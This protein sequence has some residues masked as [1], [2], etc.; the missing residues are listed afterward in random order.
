MRTAQTF[1]VRN[2]ISILITQFFVGI[3]FSYF[4]R[5]TCCCT[6]SQG[7]SA[8]IVASFFT[9]KNTCSGQP[10]CRF[11]VGAFL[12]WVTLMSASLPRTV[13]TMFSLPNRAW[14][15]FL[16]LSYFRHKFCIKFML[17]FTAE[18][19]CSRTFTKASPDIRSGPSASLYLEPL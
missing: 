2:V 17:K 11:L 4:S 19:H 10:S 18:T 8:R 3:T 9:T 15:W 6:V 12:C 16:S 7:F 14:S 1:Q 13:L 5:T